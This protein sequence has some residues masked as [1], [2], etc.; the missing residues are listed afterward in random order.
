MP[1]AAARSSRRSSSSGDRRTETL[2]PIT[3]R[4]C[5]TSCARRFPRRERA[6]SVQ[7]FRR[8]SRYKRAG[9]FVVSGVCRADPTGGN[10][11]KRTIDAA[12]AFARA[13]A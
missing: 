1:R 11:M 3:R 5:R 9:V 10:V 2:S 13:V 7:A 12:P 8:G 6:H 4:P